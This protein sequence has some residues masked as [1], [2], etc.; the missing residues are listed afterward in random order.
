MMQSSNSLIRYYVNLLKSTIYLVHVAGSLCFAGNH[1][2]SVPNPMG[3]RQG[4]LKLVHQQ[5]QHSLP[6]GR[7]AGEG[8]HSVSTE[9]LHGWM[10]EVVGGEKRQQ[11]AL[12]V[13]PLPVTA[14]AC[15]NPG[16]H[17]FILERSAPSG[18]HQTSQM[19]GFK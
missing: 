15:R 16:R 3:R 7:W 1:I 10:A 6:A 5:H 13:P 18:C 12:P 4:P 17:I 19:M 8:T 11:R 14:M 2:Q 9:S